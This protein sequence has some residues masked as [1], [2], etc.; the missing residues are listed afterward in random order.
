MAFARQALD[1]CKLTKV[2]FLVEP[3]PRRKQGV[4]AL[5]HRVQMVQLSV[6]K[7]PKL[8]SIKI[9]QARFNVSETLPTLK[10]LFKGA[11]L[12]LLFGDDV[13]SH[14]AGWPHIEQLIHDVRFVI[15]GRKS[16][17]SEV[18]QQLKVL[19]R[20]RGLKLNYTLFVSPEPD[21]ASS[22][23]RLSLKRGNHPKG[24][25][26]VVREYI[27]ANGLYHEPRPTKA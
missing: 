16:A 9:E 1:K 15:G 21:Y 25:P 4:R 5:E 27:E 11:E 14:L 18:K 23:I 22:R 26:E 3:R 6:A 8:G 24:L 2:F 20:T 7:E 12:H 10:E 17:I 19:D 13:L